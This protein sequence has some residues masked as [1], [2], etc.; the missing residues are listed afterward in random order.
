MTIELGSQKLLP[1]IIP[2]NYESQLL[3]ALTIDQSILGRSDALITPLKLEHARLR[4]VAHAKKQH[5]YIENN[6]S[7]P[8][9]MT[10]PLPAFIAAISVAF[11]GA[12]AEELM[13]VCR[14]VKTELY[15]Y[16]DFHFMSASYRLFVYPHYFEQSLVL[17]ELYIWC[18]A[19]MKWHSV[20]ESNA[21]K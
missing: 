9:I 2:V 5:L 3:C 20:F 11:S 8:N 19:I 14:H 18:D 10:R 13:A 1:N 17:M 16:I 4:Y 21:L 6:N 12:L 7:G 15:N